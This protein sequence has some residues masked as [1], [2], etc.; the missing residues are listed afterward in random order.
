MSLAY[1]LS[2][3][4]HIQDDI[5]LSW[6]CQRLTIDMVQSIENE[7]IALCEAATDRNIFIKPCYIMASLPLLAR[8]EPNL[9]IIRC[10]EQII[11]LLI[12][13][14]DTGYAKLPISFWRTAMHYEQYLGTPLVRAGLENEFAAALCQWL[15]QAPRNCS[16]LKLAL[17]RANSKVTKAIIDHCKTEKRQYMR[18]N[19]FKRAAII[20]SLHQNITPETLIS[21]SRRKNINKAMKKLSEQGDVRIER[22]SKGDDVEEWITDFFNMED[23]GWKHERGSSILSCINETYLYRQ[24]IKNALFE[25]NIIFSRL[26]LD[27]KVIAYTLD[28]ASGTHSYCLKSA[29]HQDYRNCSPGVIMEFNTLKYYMTQERYKH[30]D[31]CTDPNNMMLNALWPDRKSLLDLVVARKGY[32]FSMVFK[33]IIIIKSMIMKK[34]GANNG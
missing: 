21:Q 19:Q 31:S 16:F 4:A 26:C 6:Q 13:R 28:I 17:L 9:L 1:P 5:N 7:W 23:S 8:F 15:D 3:S 10:N 32:V 22:L 11:G 20:P 18:L 33:I 27:D 25:E 30:I 2:D 34:N 14:R 29:I 24:M 12:L